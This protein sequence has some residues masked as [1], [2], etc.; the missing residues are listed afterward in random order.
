MNTLIVVPSKEI[1]GNC[2]K[3]I[4]SIASGLKWY[5]YKEYFIRKA[6]YDMEHQEH[7][8]LPLLYYSERIEQMK[9][10]V[11][12]QNLYSEQMKIEGL[13]YSES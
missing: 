10:M 4:M 12:V 3:E 1:I 6:K 7:L 8:P 13:K 5:N 2:L 11:Q 9:R